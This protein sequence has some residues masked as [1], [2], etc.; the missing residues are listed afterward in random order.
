MKHIT[1]MHAPPATNR[2]TASHRI[3]VRI[4]IIIIITICTIRQRIRITI[5]IAG[6]V[7]HSTVCAIA[8]NICHRSNAISGK[9][10]KTTMP[11]E[12]LPIIV[13]S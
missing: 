4:I 2:E 8:P 1:Y 3:S 7:D 13:W 6:D 5:S 10:P 9:R 11:M 12:M